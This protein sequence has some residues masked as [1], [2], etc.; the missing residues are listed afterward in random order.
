MFLMSQKT[1]V[2]PCSLV[3]YQTV[4]S[5]NQEA[6]RLFSSGAKRPPF[7]VV[8]ETQTAGRG[9]R[10]RS[11]YSDSSGGLYYSLCVTP[12]V[13]DPEKLAYYHEHV[14]DLISDV[15]QTI[16]GVR[17]D[18]KAPNDLYI[19]VKKL[20]GTLFQS[21]IQMGETVPDCMVIGVGINVNQDNFPESISDIATSLYQVTGKLYDLSEFVTLLTKELR[22]VFERD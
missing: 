7:V 10:G 2:K 9:Q 15:I 17:P 16:S 6:I 21:Q 1:A 19:G 18:F 8:S 5:T 12:R 11:W 3:R 22:Y 14:A 13:Y 4:D 20:C